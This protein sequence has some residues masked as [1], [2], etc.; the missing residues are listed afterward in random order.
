M[1]DQDNKSAITINANGELSLTSKDC[2]YFKT[3]VQAGKDIYI[4]LINCS[5]VTI[6]GQEI[7]LDLVNKVEAKGY[8]IHLQAVPGFLAPEPASRARQRNE[9]RPEIKDGKEVEDSLRRS[10]RICSDDIAHKRKWSTTERGILEDIY[11]IA[12]G[13]GPDSMT[14]TH[15]YGQAGPA[16]DERTWRLLQWF[17]WKRMVLVVTASLCTLI[18]G[19]TLLLAI[20]LHKQQ[21]LWEILWRTARE[22]DSIIEHFYDWAYELCS[23]LTPS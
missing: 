8:R 7:L 14:R 5:I 20:W 23:R 9:A 6:N 3:V 19:A 1:T 16:N 4:T 22:V 2:A 10:P 11:L 17:D 18:V 21:H 15:R 13:S 12:T